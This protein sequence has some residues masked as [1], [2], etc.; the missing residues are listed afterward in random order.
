MLNKLRGLERAV[1]ELGTT[2]WSH[3]LMRSSSEIESWPKSATWFLS[4]SDNELHRESVESS[5]KDEKLSSCP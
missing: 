1:I 2:C 5:L 4:D 3:W